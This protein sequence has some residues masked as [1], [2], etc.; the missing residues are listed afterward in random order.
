MYEAPHQT[1]FM[2]V[3]PAETVAIRFWEFKS[4]TKFFCF[5]SF[6]VKYDTAVKCLM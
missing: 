6:S 5:Y 3:E 1:V 2:K 4:N